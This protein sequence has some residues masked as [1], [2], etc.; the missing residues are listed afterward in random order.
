MWAARVALLSLCIALCAA[1]LEAQPVPEVRACWLTQYTYLGRTEPQLR[2]IAQNMRA[3]GLN[4]VYFNVYGGGGVTY[5]PSRAFKAAGGNWASNSFDWTA[6]LARIF[7]DEGLAVGAWFEYG[8]ALSSLSHPV[9]VAHPAWLAR[10]AA[11]SAVTG[12]NG[13]F[14]FL[15]PGHPE[16]V[17]LMTAMARELAEDYDLDDIQLDRLRWGRRSTGREYGY[18]AVTAAR[19]QAQFGVTPP[20]NVHQANWVTFREGLV[21]ELVS[22]CYGAI[23]SADPLVVVSSAPTGSY[24]WTQHMQRWN[25]WTSGGYMDLVLPQMYTTS[26]TS[27]RAEFDAQRAAAGAAV[28]RLGVGY[29]AQE[30]NDWTA[31]RSQLDYARSR[32]VPHGCL[33][34]Y[35]NYSGPI[36]IQDELDNLPLAGNPWAIAAT[37]PFVS[38]RR[39]TLI[40]DDT[41]APS[42]GA[43]YIETGPWTSSA[44]PDF[45]GFGSRVASGSA[46][47]SATFEA[48]I[49]LSGSYEV[50]VWWTASSNRNAATEYEVHHA[51]GTAT[52][53]RDQRTDGGRWVALGQWLFAEGARA[54]RV[55]VTNRGAGPAVFT[56]ADGVRLVRRADALGLCT[57][58]VN[59]QGCTPA[60]TVTG[61]ASLTGIDPLRV[62]ATGVLNQYPG[63]YFWG[64]APGA[65]PFFGGEL[66]VQGTLA[67]G[68]VQFAGGSPIG[69]VDCSGRF[70]FE[71]SNAALA[72]SGLAPGATVF[73]QF[74]SRDPLHLDGAGIGITAGLGF[75]VEP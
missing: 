62:V 35:H 69:V 51:N 28:A 12:E 18:E 66:C 43:A 75:V 49:P 5:W 8:L 14:V 6:H 7:R 23:K 30:T 45:F 71:W 58:K 2:A 31:V 13:G 21:D 46:P 70:E 4:T 53:V 73:G 32:G 42:T 39:H 1:P 40:V 50:F 19:Y 25:H 61:R 29:R 9:A 24:G 11:G 26:L 20:T 17:A 68:A 22:A 48:S 36:A 65:S 60:L 15:T 33:W 59:S 55:T 74:W 41:A 57:A 56:S 44:Q 34:V 10:D 54:P 3:G 37:N 67:R 64:L 16:V 27:F 47:A 72:A 52:V 63:L 38:D